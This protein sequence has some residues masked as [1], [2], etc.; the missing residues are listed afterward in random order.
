MQ[1][2]QAPA[3]GAPPPW[4][5]AARPAAAAALWPPRWTAGSSARAAA[6]RQRA[7][8]A[9]QTGGAAAVAAVR[10]V[11]RRR[12]GSS[13]RGDGRSMMARTGTWLR[14]LS[15][16]CWTAARASGARVAAGLCRPH[17]RSHRH[18]VLCISWPG[19]IQAAW[20]PCARQACTIIDMPGGERAACCC[21][22][23]WADQAMHAYKRR[24]T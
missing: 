12:G 13:R 24:P 9:A 8:A 10:V 19:L 3:A 16:T 18:A 4:S 6:R 20:P 17:M 15:G 1:A 14:S 21:A 11:A 7:R 22:P 5:T 2:A 23:Q